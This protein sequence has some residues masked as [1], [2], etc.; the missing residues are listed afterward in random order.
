MDIWIRRQACLFAQEDV[1]FAAAWIAIAARLTL[2]VYYCWQTKEAK[3]QLVKV[4]ECM[5]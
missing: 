5:V 4:E 1:G 2:C 3:H